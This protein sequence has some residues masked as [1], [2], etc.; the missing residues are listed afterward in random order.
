MKDLN[1]LL[2]KEFKTSSLSKISLKGG[3]INILAQILNFLIQIGTLSIM[4]RII[5]PSGFGI[6]AMAGSVTGF[7]MIFKD[8][9]LSMATVQKEEINEQ[10]ISN[11]FWINI[12]IGI[13]LACLVVAISPLVAEFFMEPE[14]KF[15][16]IF[17]SIGLFIGALTIQHQALLRRK[18]DFFSLAIIDVSAKLIGSVISI[19]IAYKLKN[20]WPLVLLPII[21]SF[22]YLIGVLIVLPWKPKFYKK[23]SNTGDLLNFG[24]NMTV[25]GVIN[26]FARTG[27]NII[28]G[29]FVGASSLGFY[30]RAYSLMMLPIGQLIAPLTSV[31][32][33][34]LSRL[35]KN[36]NDFRKH[37][38]NSLMLIAYL[39][40]PLITTL[41]ILG[42][43]VVLIVLG[44]KW[45]PAIELYQILCFAAFWQP[46]LSTTGWILTSLN[47]T[48]RIVKWGWINSILLLLT[49][50]IGINWEVKG[51]TIA[52]AI[53][54]WVIVLPNFMF[55][56]KYT[57]VKISDFFK[58]I[59]KPIIN[60]LILGAIFLAFLRFEI[61]DII[62][63]V[64]ISILIFITFWTFLFFIDKKLKVQLKSL[65]KKLF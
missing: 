21:I 42:R 23:K 35:Q 61:D 49:F 39:T 8:L 51:L 25:Y 14:I 60:T 12:L 44:E 48:K 27:D 20:Y 63:R 16:L 7:I 3:A 59:K 58:A 37:Y 9:G 31:M 18:M 55:V 57:P 6:V 26:Y 10:Q 30:S 32:V 52:Y 40:L 33:P 36:P 45:V 41:G 29:K 34:T 24:K 64:I 43:D 62:L 22:F 15:I 28:I 1:L 4:A 46:M 50:L 56:I 13:G 17:S 54:M 53:Y 5:P 38:S 19:L 47:Q 65:V 2:N 11:L